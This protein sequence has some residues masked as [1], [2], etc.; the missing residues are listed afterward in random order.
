MPL[1][2]FTSIAKRIAGT[3]HLQASTNLFFVCWP[4]TVCILNLALPSKRIPFWPLR[5]DKVQGLGLGVTVGARILWHQPLPKGLNDKERHEIREPWRRLQFAQV[6]NSSRRDSKGFTGCWQSCFYDE[7][8]I[9]LARQAFRTADVHGR[10]GMVGA[11]VS[12]ARFDHMKRMDIQ[13]CRWCQQN[14]VPRWEHV[15]LCLSWFR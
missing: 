12:D 8:R 10:A 13:S 4:A 5:S 6:L 1:R 9:T 15:S 11:I 2:R 3:S 14:C 7:A